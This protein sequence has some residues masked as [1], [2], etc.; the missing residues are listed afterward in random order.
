VTRTPTLPAV[1]FAAVALALCLAALGAP[2]QN[3]AADNKDKDFDVPKSWVLD[4]LVIDKALGEPLPNISISA[5]VDGQTRAYATDD[6]G[7]AQIDYTEATKYL[8]VSAKPDHYVPALRSWN[9]GVR[10]QGPI[11]DTFKLE[12]ERGTTVGGLVTNE[13]GKPIAGVDVQFYF[14]SKDDERN[15]PDAGMSRAGARTDGNGRWRSDAVPAEMARIAFSLNHPDYVGDDGYSS[16]A[17][18]PK[19]RDMSAVLVMKK[20]ISVSGRVL[21]SDGKPIAGARL[22]L[23]RGRFSGGNEP[24]ARSDAQGRFRFRQ[25]KPGE[26]MVLT[27]RAKGR[28]PEQKRVALDA[29]EVEDLEVRLAPGNV[30][31]GRIVD[32]KG[33]PVRGAIVATESWRDGQLNERFTTDAD[34]RFTW[35]DAPADEVVFSAFK[36]GF[37]SIRDMKIKG[38]EAER[39]LTL[40]PVLHVTGTVVDADTGKPINA[41]TLTPGILFAQRGEGQRPRPLYWESSRAGART[42]AAGKFETQFDEPRDGHALRV[43]AEGYLPADSRVFKDDEG[44]IALEFKLKK[45]KPIL[46]TLVAAADGTPLAGAD[47]VI[48]QPGPGMTYVR[49]GTTDHRDNAAV[50]RSDE[51]GH[52]RIPPQAG[53]FTLLITHD[54]GYAEVT[55]E[56]LAKSTD[57]TVQP[58]SKIHGVYRAGAKPVA[59]KALVIN[60]RDRGYDDTAPRIYHYVNATTDKDGHFGFDHVPPGTATVGYHVPMGGG[61]STIAIL[62][63]VDVTPGQDLEL[64]VGGTGRPVIGRVSVPEAL[65][66][67][68]AWSDTRP[69]LA[70]KADYPRADYPDNYDE[71]DDAAREKFHKAWQDSPKMK[72]YQKG[73]ELNTMFVVQIKPDGSFRVEDVPAGAY[74]FGVTATSNDRPDP[75]FGGGTIIGSARAEFTVPE[76]PGGRSDE[77]LDL[78]TIEMKPEPP[79]PKLAV[80]D[81]VP[82]FAATTLDGQPLKLSDYRGK[83]VLAHFWY[84]I[85]RPAPADL[86]F[87]KVAHAQYA[88]DPR[89]VIIG[90]SLDENPNW[91]RRFAA[92]NQVTWPQVHLTDPLRADLP[93]RWALNRSMLYLIGPDGKLVARD[94]KSEDLNATLEAALA[95]AKQ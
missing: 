68:F 51:S 18:I 39:Q 64:N 73:N 58:W 95:K 22:V 79:A 47:L 8:S 50:A 63:T 67:K 83:F 84:T 6:N 14:Q 13:Q 24:E 16:T 12:M 87:L 17:P 26:A 86:P 42:N 88:N 10:G 48:V 2:A 9:P 49:D 19:L 77:P 30:I 92:R 72:A 89:L 69:R 28:A 65:T 62:K 23:G 91:P 94:I 52:Y 4:L 40:R 15:R 54:R 70:V 78:G 90:L 57:V 11:P 21:D 80:G 93:S 53:T 7:H 3:K 37:L 32:A 74:R 31:A 36:Q 1:T 34:G 41:F 29:G 35:N 66:G 20:G 71:M 27:A 82:D 43:N 81:T 59:D 75:R 45:G 60:R 61:T 55:S 33:N 25:V 46:G 56:Q 85:Q 44:E 76:L 5:R 38:G